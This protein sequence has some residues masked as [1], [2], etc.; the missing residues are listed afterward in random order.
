MQKAVRQQ[1][2][3]DDF[4]GVSLRKYE[5]L[6]VCMGGIWGNPD[7]VFFFLDMRFWIVLKNMGNVKKAWQTA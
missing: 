1:I 4:F 3:A 5:G 7:A 2:L 6:Y